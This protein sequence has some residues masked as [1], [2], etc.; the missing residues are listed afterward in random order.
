MR[1]KN[2]HHLLSDELTIC[3]EHRNRCRR[4]EARGEALNRDQPGPGMGMW[5]SGHQKECKESGIS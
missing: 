1:K 3:A 4:R 5:A 2:S